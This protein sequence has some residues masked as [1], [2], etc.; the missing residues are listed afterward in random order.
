MRSVHAVS[1]ALACAA[2]V[3]AAS[4]ATPSR[5]GDKEVDS[6]YEMKAKSLEGKDV[7]LSEYKGKVVLV[8]NVASECGYTPQY[9]GLQKL[10]DDLSSKGFSV[11]GFP[12]ND[13]GKQEPGDAATIRKFCDSKYH[14]TFPLFEKCV[15]K[16]G[17][18]QSPIYAFLAK[19]REAPSW[20]FCKYLVGKDGKVRGFYNSKVK[21]DDKQLRADIEAALE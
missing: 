5:A 16:P 15:T 4:L 11:L 21:P 9:A 20:N 12:S 19:G 17:A 18:E 1:V 13:F 2:L 6:L 8:V 7:A 3:A 14:V 10:H